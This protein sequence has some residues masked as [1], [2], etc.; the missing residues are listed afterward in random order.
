[1]LT[2]SEL[3]ALLDYNPETGAF[4]WR[5]RPSP[6]IPAGVVAGCLRPDGRLAITI[7][8][9]VYKAHRLAFLWMTGAWPIG[10][11]DHINGMPAD[12]SWVNLRDITPS[13]N[14]HNRGGAQINNKSGYLGV[15]FRRSRNKW[16][17][18]IE[19]NGKK[20]H[21]GSFATPELAHAAYLKAKDELHP[22]H[23]RLRN[24]VST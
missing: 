20:V 23:K 11:A 12:N 22:T 17:A 6:R 21:L 8:K 5:M 2:Q 15:W 13:Q 16:V 9:K 18:V 3:K 19:L 10:E 4:T 7:A 1:M 24:T 14:Q